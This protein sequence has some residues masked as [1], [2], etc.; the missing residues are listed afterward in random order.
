M[1][2]AVQSV[3]K[4]DDLGQAMCGRP[5]S[6]RIIEREL[7]ANGPVVQNASNVDGKG[8]GGI[9]DRL[10]DVALDDGSVGEREWC[11]SERPQPCG[12]CFGLL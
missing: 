11:A 2:N 1:D 5:N 8:N 10:L 3:A 9:G 12:G 7:S 6:E 4:N